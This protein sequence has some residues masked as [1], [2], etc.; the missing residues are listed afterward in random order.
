MDSNPQ[1][2]AASMKKA[3]ASTAK[4]NKKK[5]TPDPASTYFPIKQM[6]DQLNFNKLQSKGA[7]L[8]IGEGQRVGYQPPELTKR[9]QKKGVSYTMTGQQDFYR[10]P[11]GSGDGNKGGA[12]PGLSYVPIWSKTKAPKPVAPQAATQQTANTTATASP[13]ELTVPKI[14]MPTIPSETQPNPLSIAPLMSGMR[15]SIADGITNFRKNKSAAQKTGATARGANQF[16]I[17]PGSNA[18]GLNMGM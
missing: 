13:T 3:I 12:G 4:S 17:N 6:T 10:P 1:A 5:T 8:K 7:T 9:Q 14:E 15:V 16:R 2:I 11:G 18:S